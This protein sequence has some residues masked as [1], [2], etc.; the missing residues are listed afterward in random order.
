MMWK[1]GTVA[2]L[3]SVLWLALPASALDVPLAYVRS[4]PGATELPPGGN[5]FLEA[6]KQPPAGEWKLPP[7][8]SKTPLYS[9]VRLAGQERLMIMDRQGA[10][11]SF[12]N[13]IYFD[14]NGNRDLTDDLPL[15]GNV[16]TEGSRIRSK[17]P[18]IDFAATIDGKPLVY[19]VIPQVER[20]FL[21]SVTEFLVRVLGVDV[22]QPMIRLRPNCAYV[23]ELDVEGQRFHITLGDRDVNGRFD[24][25]LR[26]FPS[27]RQDT[28]AEYAGDF[29]EIQAADD[30]SPKLLQMLGD[31]LVIRGTL[32]EVHVD[33]AAGKMSLLPCERAIAPVKLPGEFETLTLRTDAA[34]PKG[35]MMYRPAQTVPLPCAAYRLVQY[36]LLR[37]DGQG[38]VWTLNAKDTNE[39]KPI[40]VAG[41]QDNTMA[42][43]EPF[44]PIVTVR[45]GKIQRSFFW[46]ASAKLDLAIKGAGNEK[47]DEIAHVSGD[48]TTL[49]LSAMNSRSPQAPR[50]KVAKPGGEVVSQ[51]TF[52]Y[53]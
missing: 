29:V 27:S 4:E 12:Y 46:G 32:F 2:F 41:G 13:L 53:G 45:D 3:F 30:T 51:G 11:D 9:L 49:P 48:R 10:K 33:V 14:A 52:E 15:K 6:G 23:G 5:L 34:I 20:F 21:G 36:D 24:D 47:V 43:G 44:S 37:K 50:Y 17:F 39:C 25:R 19:S 22:D 31:L 40:L 28:P 8:A 35:V 18:P 1:A 16:V 26:S 7:L 42:Y 38:D